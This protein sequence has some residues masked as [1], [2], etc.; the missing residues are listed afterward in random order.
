MNGRTN[1]AFFDCVAEMKKDIAVLKEDRKQDCEHIG[2][3]N[4]EMGEVE[5]RLGKIEQ[6]LAVILV[7]QKGEIAL[8]SI[9]GAMILAHLFGINI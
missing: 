2:T 7:Y 5:K 9:L 8:I 6:N 1:Q 3:L 4:R